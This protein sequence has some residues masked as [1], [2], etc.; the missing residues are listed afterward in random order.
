MSRKK[1]YK[2]RRKGAELFLNILDSVIR[3]QPDTFILV[4]RQKAR[5]EPPPV[6]L[7]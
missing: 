6:S 3:L 1:D 7:R 5:P 2:I 4:E